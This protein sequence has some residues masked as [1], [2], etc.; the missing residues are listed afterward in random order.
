MIWVVLA[1][2]LAVFVLLALVRVG[3]QADYGD[4]SL[5]V[6]LRIG[7]ASFQVFPLRPKK[8]KA[9][10]AAAPKPTKEPAEEPDTEGRSRAP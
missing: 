3:V 5:T 4:D 8:Q 10:K 2:I 1:C 7:P 9:K 6:R